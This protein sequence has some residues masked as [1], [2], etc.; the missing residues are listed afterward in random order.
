MA[1]NTR[2]KQ[3]VID[4]FVTYVNNQ[5]AAGQYDASRI[6]NIDET[7]IYFDLAGGSTLAG[8]GSRTVSVRTTGSAARCTVLL[9]VTMVGT[10]LPPY[11]IFKGSANGRISR[12]F[13]SYPA[14]Q[15]Y[16]TT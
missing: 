7:N 3:S 4:D 5:T 6:V 14:G 2:Y 9:G 8:R 12:E 15:F 1:Q 16:T 11:I 13:T 10:K